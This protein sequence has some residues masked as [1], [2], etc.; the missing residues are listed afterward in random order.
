MSRVFTIVHVLLSLALAGVC[1]LQWKKERTLQQHAAELTT[2]LRAE[3][4]AR[5]EA[6][7]KAALYEQEIQRLTRLRDEA[8]NAAQRLSAEATQVQAEFQ[9]RTQTLTR[10]TAEVAALNEQLKAAQAAITGRNTEVTGQNT[11]ITEANT[12]LKKLT[13]ERDGLVTKLNEQ[14]RS[15]NEL[16]EKHNKLVREK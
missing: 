5:V 7:A 3:N 2:T 1:V 11:A 6:Q 8:E 15:Y 14:I 16:A 10:Q 13:A 4:L 12:L 9:L